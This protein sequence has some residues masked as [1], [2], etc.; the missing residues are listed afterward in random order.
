MGD[1]MR[2]PAVALHRVNDSE[3]E[4][5]FAALVAAHLPGL[6]A[7]A[8]QL[9]RTHIDPDDL[10]QEALMRAC[11]ARHQLGNPDSMRN[12][13]LTI[14]GNTFIDVIRKQRRH[15]PQVPL[16]VDLED[17]QCD[18]MT[19]P[20]PWQRIGTDELRHAIDQLP[21]DLRD[22]YRLFALEGKD[23]VEI[24]A[25]VGIPKSTVGTRLLRARQKLRALLA[26]LAESL[27]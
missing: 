16:D 9:C 20:L 25:I 5:A 6:R 10:L 19:E 17:R 26:T 14:V 22:T 2:A 18:E 15:P 12:W 23:Y 11:R 8:S 13:L 3:N 4:R 27:P 7:R 21:K 1:P 24:A